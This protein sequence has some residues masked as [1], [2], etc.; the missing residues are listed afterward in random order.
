MS[1]QIDPALMELTKQFEKKVNESKYGDSVADR[2]VLTVPTTN[3]NG[4][5]T[6]NDTS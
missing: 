1:L 2:S 5:F 3:L 4:E 6:N